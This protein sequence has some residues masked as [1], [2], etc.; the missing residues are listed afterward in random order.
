LMYAPWHPGTGPM[1]GMASGGHGRIHAAEK[2]K[3]GGEKREG[4]G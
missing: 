1:Y 3:G 2:K 4:Q